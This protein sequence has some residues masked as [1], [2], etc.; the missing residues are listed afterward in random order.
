MTTV[1]FIE[2]QGLGGY[3]GLWG[4]MNIKK[5]IINT[6]IC[7]LIQYCTIFFPINYKCFWSISLFSNTVILSY[8]AV[9]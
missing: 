9:S 7:V 5:C 6:I 2:Q 4:Q 1:V 8:L 3:L